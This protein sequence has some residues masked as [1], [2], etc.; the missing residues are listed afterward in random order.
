[1][2]GEYDN[3]AVAVPLIT[4][5]FYFWVRA[6]RD[7]TSWPWAIFAA[8]SY[9]CLVATWGGYVFA[10]NMIALHVVALLMHMRLSWK[11]Y[12]AYSTFYVFGTAGALQ[13]T[14]VGLQPLRSTEQLMPLVVF[15]NLQV[16][17]AQKPPAR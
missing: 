2:A 13:F 17:D 3:E 16:N 9:V 5:T 7:F 12:A 6:L 8:F 1:M 4:C 15:A 14:V 10:L 11:V